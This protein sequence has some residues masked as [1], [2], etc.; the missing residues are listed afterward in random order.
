MKSRQYA[1]LVSDVT[2]LFPPSRNIDK[3]VSTKRCEIYLVLRNKEKDMALKGK[4]MC[5]G[6]SRILYQ[7][8]H[9]ESLFIGK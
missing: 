5:C 2:K 8:Y 1:T 6:I 9:A 4:F 3:S 7:R